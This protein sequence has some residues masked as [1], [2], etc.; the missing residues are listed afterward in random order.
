MKT[1]TPSVLIILL[2]GFPFVLF[3]QSSAF[4]LQAEPVDE[5][6]PSAVQLLG[7]PETEETELKGIDNEDIGITGESEEPTGI[8]HEDIGITA[9]DDAALD[10]HNETNLEFIRERASSSGTLFMNKA[11]LVES[12]AAEATSLHPGDE[13]RVI[14]MPAPGVSD[15][16]DDDDSRAK[17]PKEIVIV[18]SKIREDEEL[19][20][21]LHDPG[22]TLLE[23]AAV[24]DAEDLLLYAA[25][26]ANE[27][28]NVD[29]IVLSSNHVGMSYDMRGR[30]LGFV[31]VKYAVQVSVEEIY[32]DE[33]GRVK[34][35]FP[36]WHFLVRK[37]MSAEEL[38]TE[39]E[40]GLELVGLEPASSEDRPSESISLNFSKI[41]AQALQTMSNVMKAAHDTAMNAIRNMRA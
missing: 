34:V 13:I 36:W 40:K 11:D 9:E 15:D 41:R 6:E 12:I 4:Q 1:K 37:E 25:Q 22:I 31:Q 16:D 35:Q 14:L 17:K 38:K 24:E 7:P 8:E 23:I 30:L 27:D 10:Q 3:A 32:T 29:D 21:A 5:P 20:E 39:L 19:S 18:G 33:Y 26:I 28:E 2:L